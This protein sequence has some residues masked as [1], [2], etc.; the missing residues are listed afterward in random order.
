MGFNSTVVVLNDALHE[1]RNDPEFGKNLYDAVMGLSLRP[2][3]RSRD[4]PAGYHVNAASAIETHH[5]DQ[6]HAIL[7]GGNCGT[8]MGYA[9][10][11]RV[12]WPDDARSILNN[13]GSQHGCHVAWRKY[14][15]IVTEILK[16]PE[17]LPLLL[18]ISKSLDRMIEKKLKGLP[19]EE[20]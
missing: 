10:G 4:I 3:Q 20:D 6:M 8:D 14:E 2:D 17:V 16:H 13:V 1:I 18:G 12:K 9:G 5:A 19:N 15:V 7:V 11:Y